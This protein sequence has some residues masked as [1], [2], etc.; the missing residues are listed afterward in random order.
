MYTETQVP[1]EP[2]APQDYLFDLNGYLILR[3]AVSPSHVAALNERLEEVFAAIPA[4]V[5]RSSTAMARCGAGRAGAITAFDP[6][7]P[8]NRSGCR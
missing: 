7:A 8:G 2:T 4:S 3:D 6:G 5:G 1:C